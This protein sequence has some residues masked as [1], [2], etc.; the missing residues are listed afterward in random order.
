M[1]TGLGGSLFVR[2]AMRLDY[3]VEAAIESLVPV[4]DDVV[5]LDCHSTDGTLDLLRMIE[6]RH[7]NVRVFPNVPWEQAADY[8][9]L[10]ILANAAREL[11][12]ARW[13]FMIQADEVLHES[14]Y[15]ALRALVA[16]DGW[17][18]ETFRVRRLNLYGDLA[19][20]VGLGSRLK[21]CSD[22]P[23]RIGLQGVPAGGDAESIVEPLGPDRR[24]VDRVTLFHYGF[25]RSGQA[26]ITKAIEMQSWFWGA[27]SV[28]DH[29]VVQMERDG[30][31]FRPYDIIPLGELSPLPMP[32]PQAAVGWLAGRTAYGEVPR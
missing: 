4:C 5:V 2:D 3:C 13:H 6:A 27:H 9:R 7:N 11:V 30:T 19:H 8:Q 25:V 17:G 12:R 23:T 20:H 29:R 15:P 14:S 21:P 31:G 16:A 28:P 10:M 24:M 26:L 22:E 18:R 32:H 1:S